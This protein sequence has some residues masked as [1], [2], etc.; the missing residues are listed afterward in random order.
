MVDHG[1]ELFDSIT[2]EHYICLEVQHCSFMINLLDRA[3]KVT[4]AEE[5]IKILTMNR[6]LP[7]GEHCS[8]NSNMVAAERTVVHV[9]ELD[10]CNTPM[11]RVLL[12]D[13]YAASHHQKDQRM[14][15]ND[16]G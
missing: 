16:I 15:R 3:G 5:F 1:L 13:M 7:F 12:C 10:P 9:V 2:R 14:L 4:K 8:V 6:G 11:A